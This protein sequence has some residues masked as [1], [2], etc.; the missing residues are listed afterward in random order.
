MD[1]TE[2]SWAAVMTAICGI[3]PWSCKSGTYMDGPVHFI[4]EAAGLDEMS[5]ARTMLGPVGELGP[6]RTVSAEVAQ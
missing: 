6:G 4:H 3:W 2:A 5:L 1:N